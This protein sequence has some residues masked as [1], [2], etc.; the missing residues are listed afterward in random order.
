MM[1]NLEKALLIKPN[2][3]KSYQV[4]CNETNP[5]Q[6]NNKYLCFSAEICT[7]KTHCNPSICW[8]LDSVQ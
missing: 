3:L 5:D 8:I 6:T 2:P 1:R 4:T 7:N